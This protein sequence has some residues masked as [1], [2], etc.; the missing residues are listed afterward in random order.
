MFS[1][2][3]IYGIF[4]SGNAAI[5]RSEVNHPIDYDSE[6]NSDQSTGRPMSA[7]LLDVSVITYCFTPER[8]YNC[9][10]DVNTELEEK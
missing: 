7:L 10:H 5:W 8:R 1:P 9:D 4:I 6:I 2:Q 3:N